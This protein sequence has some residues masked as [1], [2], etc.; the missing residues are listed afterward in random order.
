MSLPPVPTL[1]VKEVHPCTTT[2]PTP[3]FVFTL[4]V[5]GLSEQAKLDGLL[6][7]GERIHTLQMRIDNDHHLYAHS[8]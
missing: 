4:T 5:L 6:I 8:Q 1:R 3:S 7:D 2:T